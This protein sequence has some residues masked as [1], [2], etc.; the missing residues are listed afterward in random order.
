[1]AKLSIKLLGPF[2]AEL[3][4]QPLTDFRSDKVRA[5]LAYLSVETQRPWT[6][7]QLADLFWAD[8]QESKAQANLRNALSNLRRL[9]GDVQGHSPFILINQSTLQ[10][11]PGA[12]YWLDVNAF[13]DLTAGLSPHLTPPFSDVNHYDLEHALAI[14][15]GNFMAGFNI[16][17]PAFETWMVKTRENLRHRWVGIL[18]C[19]SLT[20]H[21]NGQFDLALD[22][23]DAWIEQE[24]WEEEAY[25][26]SM[27]ILSAIGHRN[28]ALA[29]FEACQ[30][31]LAEDL[32]IDPELE[33]VRLY[34]RIKQGSLAAPASPIHATQ[35]LRKTL[36]V[37]PGPLPG[38][39]QDLADSTFEPRLFVARQE[40]L[41]QLRTWLADALQGH[42]QAAFIMGEPGSGKTHLLMKFVNQALELYPDLLVLWGQCNAFTGQ[43]D[44]YFPF[45]NMTRILAGDV[46]P[47]VPGA[48]SSPMHLQRVWR[49]LPDTL[50][51]LVHH[52]PDLIKR[53]LPSIN[54]FKLAN[55]HLGVA[56]DL[57]DT[58]Q[59]LITKP[60]PSQ[61]SQPLL[62]DQFT[63]V[64]SNLSTENP[65]ILVL[66]DLQWIDPGSTS[67]L[68]HLGRLVAGKRILLLGAFRPEEVWH[69]RKDEVH[70]LEGILHGFQ[71]AFGEM[72]ID[73]AESKGQDFVHA[74]LDS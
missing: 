63:Q 29:R 21:R 37:D 20:H 58:I 18:R 60:T 27:A 11:N 51:S 48:V 53:F 3:D 54:Q 57:L 2:N 39:L 7:D 5:L 8:Y 64:L 62:N 4:G 15:Q 30:K 13:L 16:D 10:F 68:F 73:L 49:F 65:L 67:L 14:Y 34:N 24:P 72:M 33:T 74:L 22:Y 23:V 66:D 38:W 25:R 28:A 26:H 6:R 36:P 50:H 59:A 17:S 42:G 47:L 56:H 46:E 31:R 32:G 52:G 9:I 1:V 40:E 43:G 61:M 19:L 45:M 41:N 55:A 70:H 44:P 12:D 35:A 69:G 71:A